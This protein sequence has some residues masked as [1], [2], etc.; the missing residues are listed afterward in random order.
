MK[1]VSRKTGLVLGAV[2]ALVTIGAG[3]GASP[4]WLG[5]ANVADEMAPGSTAATWSSGI[6]SNVP[7]AP[8]PG[9]SVNSF[10]YSVQRQVPKH[11]ASTEWVGCPNGFY[12]RPGSGDVWGDNT[13]EPVIKTFVGYSTMT[14]TEEPELQYQYSGTPANEPLFQGLKEGYYNPSLTGTHHFTMTFWCD[15]LADVNVT[16]PSL[17][18]TAAPSPNPTPATTPTVGTN[19]GFEANL[20]NAA[21]GMYLGGGSSGSSAQ[22]SGSPTTMFVAGSLDGGTTDYYNAIGYGLWS[23]G[24]G[25]SMA[26]PNLGF[27]G[28]QAFWYG[29]DSGIANGGLLLALAGNPGGGSRML[30]QAASIAV[31]DKGNVNDGTV[32]TGGQCLTAPAGASTPTLE[33]CDATNP[34]QYWNFNN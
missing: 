4:S 16:P 2:A 8:D 20:Q 31:P 27:S 28:D 34:N 13:N 17:R 15:R 6:P 9:P 21:T 18:S 12:V 32:G 19:S 24:S 33:A 3:M 10:S 25:S 26:G 23:Q 22:M 30:V 14:Q 5:T 29:S 11:S 7:L 1:R